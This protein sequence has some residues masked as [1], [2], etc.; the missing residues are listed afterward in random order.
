MI[1][2]LPAV[3]AVL[4]TALMALLLALLLARYFASTLLPR[5]KVALALHRNPGAKG[6]IGSW[7]R[8]FACTGIWFAVSRLF[9][10]AVTALYAVSTRRAEAYFSNLYG[11][12][13]KWDAPH[14]IGLIRNWYVNEGDARYHIVF[15]PMYPL[16]CRVLLPLFGGNADISAMAVS[17]LSAIAAG[18]VLY[19]LTALDYGERTAARAAKLFFAN[20][21]SF[22][23][24]LPYTE[25]LFLLLTLGTVYLARRKRV[26]WALLLGAMCAACRLMGVTVAIP[27]FYSML[28]DDRDAGILTPKRFALRFASC[29]TLLLGVEAYLLLNYQITGNPFQFWIYQR[30]HWYNTTGTLWN[31]FSYIVHYALYD[32][33]PMQ[34]AT[35]VPTVLLIYGAIIVLFAHC[36]RANVGD[37]AYGWAYMYMTIVPTW[38]ISGPRYVSGL[39]SLY[40]ML[41]DT[42]RKKWADIAL[43]AA[44]AATLGYMACMFVFTSG[45]Y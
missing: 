42:A 18:A 26:L 41:A 23:L 17:N 16:V 12:W 7:A 22:F 34:L 27:I 14:Y 11:Y 30:D 21:L 39:Y 24:S 4:G 6:C 45:V 36:R 3:S 19:Q 9:I 32:D 35:W 40:P 28:C 37:A 33:V 25:A 13:T 5:S 8:A 31:T 43:T 29:L 10:L 15:F 1:D 20:P 2:Q 38:L 44:F